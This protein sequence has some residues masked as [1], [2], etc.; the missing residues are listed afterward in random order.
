MQVE[1]RIQPH[2]TTLDCPY[3]SALSSDE[4]QQAAC[5]QACNAA[6]FHFHYRDL[7]GQ[8]WRYKKQ[9]RH[10]SRVRNL[11]RGKVGNNLC[12]QSRLESMWAS[13]SERHCKCCQC[14]PRR[15][16]P[17]LELHDVSKWPVARGGEGRTVI[18]V[19]CAAIMNHNSGYEYE[20]Y[21]PDY[22]VCDG[23]KRID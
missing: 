10:C 21:H 11:L 9:K 14:C 17:G 5:V 18:R 16:N 20:D 19:K 7:Y 4:H 8:W 15:V 1:W 23:E 2:T 6:R 22:H 12:R 3:K 13:V